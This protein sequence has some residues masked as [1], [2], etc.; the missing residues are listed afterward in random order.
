MKF[1]S[2]CKG[3]IPRDVS[4]IS[5]TYDDVTLKRAL[6]SLVK[7]EELFCAPKDDV[8][9]VIERQRKIA[10]TIGSEAAVFF[11]YKDQSY[12]LKDAVIAAYNNHW[13]IKTVPED[14]WLA[15]AE[16]VSSAINRNSH[17][18]TVRKFV[19]GKNE[20]SI[21]IHVNAY[22]NIGREP[23]FDTIS[24]KVA[25]RVKV[26]ELLEALTADFSTTTPL[27][28]VISQANFLAMPKRKLKVQ[29][30]L[31]CGI[32]HLEMDGTSEDWSRLLVKMKQVKKVLDPI[33]NE[34][35]LTEIWWGAVKL[36]FQ[37]LLEAYEGEPNHFWWSKIL[38]KEP[39]G[40]GRDIFTG[41]LI[42]FLDGEDQGDEIYMT[43]GVS[44]IPITLKTLS[45]T[46][47]KGFLLTGTAGFIVNETH[48]S[49][50]PSVI[51]CEGWSLLLDRDSEL[52]NSQPNCG[53]F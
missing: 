22:W 15:F 29:A 19:D 43:N 32:S 28:R 16:N 37:N 36:V 38:H 53:W 4:K 3:L 7:K 42:A 47:N 25:E 14:W 13:G 31:C 27:Q 23:I 1:V 24:K 46:Q 33:N 40:S 11:G 5:E 6:E 17:K 41:W 9:K 8:L 34:I 52:Y 44:K 20:E 18:E 50:A 10:A 26:P 35:G 48:Q 45:E 51:L 12:G 39:W 2:L 21:E 30:R 49:N